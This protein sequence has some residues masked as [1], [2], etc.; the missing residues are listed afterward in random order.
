MVD[1]VSSIIRRNIFDSLPEPQPRI[2][3][4][5]GMDLLVFHVLISP[6]MPLIV[7][8]PHSDPRLRV[9]HSLFASK[10]RGGEARRGAEV[11]RVIRAY[12][13]VSRVRGAGARRDKAAVL[14][15]L[16]RRLGGELPKPGTGGAKGRPGTDFLVPTMNYLWPT[17]T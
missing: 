17:A 5:R 1:R 13:R 3:C 14:G 10:G 2:K 4:L 11:L 9:H 8:F 6:W 15:L 12:R 16:Q 7:S